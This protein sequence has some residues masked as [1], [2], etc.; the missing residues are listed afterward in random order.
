M[1]NGTRIMVQMTKNNSMMM[2]DGKTLITDYFYTYPPEA[3][4]VLHHLLAHDRALLKR[5]EEVIFRKVNVPHDNIHSLALH[6]VPM[7]EN[8]KFFTVCLSGW[9]AIAP[10]IWFSGH[11]P[12][13]LVEPRLS[14]DIDYSDDPC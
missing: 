8:R 9:L 1:D 10:K 5:T 6:V 2:A 13:D 7:T 3:Q 11:G 4:A 14:G 12:C